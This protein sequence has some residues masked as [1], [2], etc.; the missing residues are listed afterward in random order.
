MGYY[1]RFTLDTHPEDRH[2]EVLNSIRDTYDDPFV[3]GPIQ[4]NG[5]VGPKWYEQHDH[6][7]SVSQK[8]PDVL[9]VITS[10]SK[11]DIARRRFYKGGKKIDEILLPMGEVESLLVCREYETTKEDIQLARE[12]YSK[13]PEVRGEPKDIVEA[14]KAC[15]IIKYSE[16]PKDVVEALI[17]LY[18]ESTGYKKDKLMDLLYLGH[19]M[20]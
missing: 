12:M 19:H 4:W 1:T 18:L 11:D 2:Q 14:L 17:V 5:G 10:L 15:M 20:S 8:F 16:I 13:I 6:C 3:E 7:M 9:I